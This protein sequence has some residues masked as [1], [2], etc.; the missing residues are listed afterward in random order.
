MAVTFKCAL[1]RL[2]VPGDHPPSTVRTVGTV[3]YGEMNGTKATR[4]DRVRRG[5]VSL[6]REEQLRGD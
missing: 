4:D 5:L 2:P 3:K 6:A 1:V